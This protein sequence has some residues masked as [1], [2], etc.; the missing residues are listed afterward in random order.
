LIT[1]GLAALAQEAFY[2]V[3]TFRLAVDNPRILNGNRDLGPTLQYRLMPTFAYPRPSLNHYIK[4]LELV[5]CIGH[6]E[7]G[8]LAR[9]AGGAY[10][11]QNVKWVRIYFL[12]SLCSLNY[13]R[14]GLSKDM[15]FRDDS[16]LRRE[17]DAFMKN[18][19]RNGVKF[20]AAGLVEF[21][22]ARTPMLSTKTGIKMSQKSQVQME[23][24]LR[25]KIKFGV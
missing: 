23:G 24:E 1:P 11:F 8:W 9:L 4:N 25:G 3:N 2:T 15:F 22:E 18:T 5:L 16:L 12:W 17:W 21:C 13:T 7:W 19:V 6:K 10:G 14:P 20:R